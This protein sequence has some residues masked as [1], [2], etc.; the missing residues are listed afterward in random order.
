[1]EQQEPGSKPAPRLVA[2][3]EGLGYGFYGPQG[4]QL[5]LEPKDAGLSEK[6]AAFAYNGL[7]I[8]NLEMETSA[9]YAMAA[10]MG[11]RAV[12]INSILA[13]RA[14]GEFSGNPGAAM[15]RLIQYTMDKLTQS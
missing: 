13:N 11:H 6:L 5:R 3:F 1:M 7:K 10:L 9:L 8:T 12:S 4:R 2:S 14:T 15:E